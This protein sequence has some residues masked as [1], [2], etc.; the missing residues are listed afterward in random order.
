MFSIRNWLHSYL[1]QN[2]IDP[3][4]DIKCVNISI[5]RNRILFLSY[6]DLEEAICYFFG[7]EKIERK[8]ALRFLSIAMFHVNLFVGSNAVDK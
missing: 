4:N 1:E 6:F 5:L 7:K 3:T 8:M 2:Y